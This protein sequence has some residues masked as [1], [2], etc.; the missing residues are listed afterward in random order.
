MCLLDG[1]NINEKSGSTN[2]NSLAETVIK[3]KADL[4]IAF[5]GDGDRVIM[6]DH[7]G[8]VVNGD[9]ILYLTPAIGGGEV[10]TLGASSE[11]K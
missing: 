4:G 6:V 1:L 5:D 10:S 3:E 9:E 11:L 7:R 8:N 2:P